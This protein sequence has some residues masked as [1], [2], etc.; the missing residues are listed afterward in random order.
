MID[1][2]ETHLHP[3][4]QREILPILSKLFPNIQFF[5]ATHSPQIVASVKSESVFICDNFNVEK[6][7]F[8]TF[9][10]DSN[11]ILNEIFNTT[12]RPIPYIKLIQKFDD[13][14]DNDASIG[15]SYAEVCKDVNSLLTKAVERRLIADVPFGAFLSGGIDSSAIV[16]LMSKVSSSRIDLVAAVKL[17]HFEE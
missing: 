3:K 11:S 13:L 15:K 8:K 12:D 2:I 5:I 14:I 9:G 6:V 16:G 10:E 17:S 1:E 4:W 7:P